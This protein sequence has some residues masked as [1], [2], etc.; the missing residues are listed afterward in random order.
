MSKYL[1]NFEQNIL[2]PLNELIKEKHRDIC[3]KDNLSLYNKVNDHAKRIPELKND[4]DR[5]WKLNKIKSYPLIMSYC[6]KFKL[7]VEEF[8]TTQQLIQTNE[9]VDKHIQSGESVDEYKQSGKSV[10]EYK[11]SGKSI[12]EYKQSGEPVDEHIQSGESVEEYKQSG[13]LIDEYK[14]SGKP[15]DEHIQSGKSV[16]EYKQH[17]TLIYKPTVVDNDKYVLKTLTR[18][19]NFYKNSK[20]EIHTKDNPK[21]IKRMHYYYEYISTLEDN[22]RLLWMISKITEY[23]FVMTYCYPFRELVIRYSKHLEKYGINIDLPSIEGTRIKI[24]YLYLF[25]V[26]DNIY[27]FG[28]TNNE[29]RREK[30]HSKKHGKEIKFIR[31]WLD[32]WLK[33]ISI[34][35]CAGSS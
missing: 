23:I 18:L 13:K 33:I 8:E 27:K 10:E 9:P 31:I 3:R 19:N 29:K 22:D 32:M 5:R 6:T 16:D 15:V 35:Y 4:S 28:K 21:L 30:E 2:I 24:G 20:R 12:D 14:Q 26:E 11:Q 17:L 1:I 34:G 7:I 25:H